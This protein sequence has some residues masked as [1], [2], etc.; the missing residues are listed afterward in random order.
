MHTN[1]LRPTARQ[2]VLLSGASSLVGWIMGSSFTLKANVLSAGMK[3]ASLAPSASPWPYPDS[4]DAVVAAPRF[5]RL[6]FENN[7]VRVLEVT[8]PPHTREPLH[9]H[10]WPSVLYKEQ[11]GRGCYYD[12]TGALVHESTTPYRKGPDLVR[13]RWQ[14]PEGPH[15]VENTD[16]VADRFIRVELKQ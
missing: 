16:E 7:R 15:A 1:L 10:R 6:L 11:T 3:V 13:A 2:L 12:A 8:V 14:E 5:H 9:T 4:L